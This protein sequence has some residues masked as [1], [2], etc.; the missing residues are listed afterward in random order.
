M[1]TKRAETKMNEMNMMP[2]VEPIYDCCMDPTQKTVH[3]AGEGYHEI[4][5]DYED[6]PTLTKAQYQ[7][8]PWSEERWRRRTNVEKHRYYTSLIKYQPPLSVKV[9]IG[10]AA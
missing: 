2:V 4:G 8:L 9:W 1:I 5:V 3:N 6:L 7:N 10:F